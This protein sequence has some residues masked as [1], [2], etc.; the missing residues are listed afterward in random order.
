MFEKPKCTAMW[1]QEIW[2]LMEG[3]SVAI[4]KQ[5]ENG[6]TSTHLDIKISFKCIILPNITNDLIFYRIYIITMKATFTFPASFFLPVQ[7]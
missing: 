7:S 5:K 1:G 4:G 2:D 3:A 6:N